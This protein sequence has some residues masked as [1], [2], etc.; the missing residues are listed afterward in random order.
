M[1]QE[2]TTTQDVSLDTTCD[3]QNIDSNRLSSQDHPPRE[4]VW[5][6]LVSVTP[7]LVPAPVVELPFTPNAHNSILLGRSKGSF[8]LLVR[9]AHL[10]L[11]TTHAECDSRCQYNDK[12][13]SGK[14][15]MFY[16]GKSTDEAN[17]CPVVYLADLRY[18]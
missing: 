9:C 16:L 10:G 7:H 4:I 5:G 6:R 11:P 12:R 14:H 3:L 17:P 1:D 13:I 2:S 18:V 15:C 8:I